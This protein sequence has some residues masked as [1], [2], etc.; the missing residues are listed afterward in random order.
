MAI[1]KVLIY[2]A[3]FA[4]TLLPLQSTQALDAEYLYKERTCIACHGTKG[5][6]PV[7]DE[8]PKIAGQPELY[9]LAQMKDIKHGRRTN[10]HSVAMK[11]VMHLISDDELAVI[12]SWLA[13]IKR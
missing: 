11:N 12:A 10:A 8:Y 5:K 9:L 13:S 7:M 4:A 6:A 2:T 3:G 1:Y